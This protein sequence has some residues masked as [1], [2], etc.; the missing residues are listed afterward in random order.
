M[1]T[2]KIKLLKELN[3]NFKK[4]TKN[5][6]V[7]SF[8]LRVTQTAKNNYCKKRRFMLTKYV[9]EKNVYTYKNFDGFF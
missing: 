3:F 6:T 7:T 8:S 5:E 9:I 2:P 1:L 4:Q